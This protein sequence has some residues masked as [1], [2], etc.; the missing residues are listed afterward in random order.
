MYPA[1][2][3]DS[4]CPPA[5]AGTGY[6]R[7]LNDWTRWGPARARVVG[8][9]ARIRVTCLSPGRHGDC[10]VTVTV[11]AAVGQAARWRWDYFKTRVHE[12]ANF[13]A[14]SPHEIAGGPGGS[15][16][17]HGERQPRT[18]PAT[19][20]GAGSPRRAGVGLHAAGRPCTGRPASHGTNSSGPSSGRPGPGGRGPR[21]PGPSLR[22]TAPA[23][24]SAAPAR[25]SSPARSP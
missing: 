9:A 15:L 8:R 12:I 14:E 20:A 11:P 17:R 24:G 21:P 3:N 23:L 13:R 2:S 6:N 25:L 5:A 10:A 4:E 18:R 16:E 7:D 22:L 1:P 19:R